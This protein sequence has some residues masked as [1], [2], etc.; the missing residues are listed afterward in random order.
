MIQNVKRVVFELGLGIRY[1]SW[2]RTGKQV[3]T[4][5]KLPSQ[6]EKVLRIDKTD[7]NY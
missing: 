4:I 3:G 2:L 6:T 7:N 1:L 5:T